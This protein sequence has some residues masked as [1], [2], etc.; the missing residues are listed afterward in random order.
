MTLL[1]IVGAV[2]ALF[3][4][5]GLIAAAFV[6]IRSGA[7][8]AAAEAWKGEAEAQKARAD[9]L[10]SDLVDLKARVLA[11][12]TDNARLKDLATGATA[13]R[14]LTELVKEQHQAVTFQIAAMTTAPTKRVPMSRDA[15]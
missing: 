1:P 5:L 10:E 3:G 9:R 15:Q 8:K 7:T 2:A 14:E 12:E 13:L 4:L 11:L 6:V